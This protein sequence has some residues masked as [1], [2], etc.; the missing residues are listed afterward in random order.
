MRLTT[1][2]ELLQALTVIVA[3]L[4]VASSTGIV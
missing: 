4:L 2:I 1:L 3:T